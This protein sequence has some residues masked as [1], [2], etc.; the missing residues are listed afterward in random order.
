MRIFLKDADFQLIQR[1][2]TPNGWNW[3]RKCRNYYEIRNVIPK[4]Y[5]LK[6]LKALDEDFLN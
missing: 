5:P 4:I 3:E 6:Y 1:F 2:N